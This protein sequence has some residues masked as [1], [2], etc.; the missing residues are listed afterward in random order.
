MDLRT[1]ALPAIGSGNR[2]FPIEKAA[3]IMVTIAAAHL[4]GPT[5]L[6]KITFSV[7]SDAGYNAFEG[8]LKLLPA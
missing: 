6:E 3:Q 1:V 8:L 7:V 4:A 5:S 2:G